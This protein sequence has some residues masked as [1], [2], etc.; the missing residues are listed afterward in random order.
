VGGGG[1]TLPE[2]VLRLRVT[3]VAGEGGKEKGDSKLALYSSSSEF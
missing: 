2:G 3:V 1:N